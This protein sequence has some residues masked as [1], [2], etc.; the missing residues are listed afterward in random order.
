MPLAI[1]LMWEQP[2]LL[3]TEVY[4]NEEY[5][6]CDLKIAIGSCVPHPAVG[7]GGGGKLILPG[8]ASFDTISWNHKAGGASMDP[9]DT[10]KK[11]TQGMGFIEQNRLKKD[12]DEAVELAG[13]DFLINTIDNL[14]GEPVAI[15]AGDWKQAFAAAVKDAQIHYRTPKILDKDIVISNS[16]AKS[17]ESM[18]SLTAAI[19]MIN[20]N[21]GD[22]VIIANAPEGQVI[23]YLGSLFGKNT[24][25]C[26]YKE[27]R[28]PSQVNK[29]IIFTEYPHRA[30]VGLKKMR[31]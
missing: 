12:I 29:V 15:Y 31:R 16:Y 19:P 13:L 1:A 10:T 8:I 24:Y 7:F 28:I 5:L 17:S 2:A 21:G 3:Q 4:I 25:A 14:W 22:I 26:Q 30:A 18:I 20:K 6:K 27:C 9:V 11:P 23:H